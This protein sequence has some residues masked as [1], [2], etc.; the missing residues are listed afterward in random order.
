MIGTSRAGRP[1]RGAPPATGH[2]D[3]R[4]E[5]DEQ[6]HGRDGG[7]DEDAVLGRRLDDLVVREGPVPAEEKPRNGRLSDGEE[8]K[9]N[10]TTT[11]RGA[12]IQS[13]NSA[14]YASCRPR[15][16]SASRRPPQDE[17]RR[18]VDHDP[19]HEEAEQH[20]QA[21]GCAALQS[22]MS[23]NRST[24]TLPIRRLRPLPTSCG[25]R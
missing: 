23:E 16:A 15:S 11:I 20:Q 10:S 21:E 24:I 6:A 14:T 25:V 13:R 22:P 12:T 2:G 7:A 3:R 1:A 9:E 18:Q 19:E 8:W 4:D 5:A 17:A